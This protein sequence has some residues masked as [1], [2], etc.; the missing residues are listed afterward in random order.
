MDL[1]DVYEEEIKTIIEIYKGK[2]WTIEEG[3][4]SEI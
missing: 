2:Y 4:D 1:W 3:D